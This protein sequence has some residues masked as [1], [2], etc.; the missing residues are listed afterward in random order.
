M[1]L[2]FS[3]CFFVLHGKYMLLL[4]GLACQY[5]TDIVSLIV[6]VVVMMIMM[7]SMIILKF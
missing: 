2:F 5:D 1:L 3:V 7:L 4:E 6:V